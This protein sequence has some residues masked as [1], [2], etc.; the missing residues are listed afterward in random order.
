MPETYYCILGNTPSLSRAELTRLLPN[1]TITDIDPTIAAIELDSD[2]LAQNLLLRS[3]GVVKIAR[4][5][6]T[7][8]TTDEDTINTTITEHLLQQDE[9]KITFA[10]AELGRDHLPALSAATIKQSLKTAGKKVRYQETTRHGLS[11]AVLSHKTVT[12]IIAIHAQTETL[13][14]QTIAVQ[15]IDHWTLKDRS[16]PYADRKKGMLP[17]KVARM[18]VNIAIGSDQ[19]QGVL[20]DPFCGSGTIL[21]E[22]MELGCSV[23]A[24]DTDTDAVL[25]TQ[26]NLKWFA[27]EAGINTEWSV[28]Q[29]DATKIDPQQPI[30]YLV[31]E[32]YLGKPKPQKDQVKNIFTGLHKM[33][34][35]AFKHW[36]KILQPGAQIVIIFPRARASQLGLKEDVTLHKL[37]DK[38]D[39]LGYTTLSEPVI[40]QRPQASIAREVYHLE[41]RGT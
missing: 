39:S 11:A 13:L 17:P 9:G 3:G 1:T 29:A 21:M 10:I 37:I 23:V 30:H 6:T 7:L 24:S 22:A 41:F 20:L 8:K 12:E 19:A 28:Q 14:C 25:G 27:Q 33:Y 2:E 36:S 35:G 4:A 26:R 34:L 18:L 32:P 16:K 38:L 40:Y 31:T 15:N 5:I